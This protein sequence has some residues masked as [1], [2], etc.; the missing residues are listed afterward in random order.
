MK[1]PGSKF[2]FQG[3][4]GLYVL[5]GE[6]FAL[7]TYFCRYLINVT[8]GFLETKK[9]FLFFDLSRVATLL[10]GY[11]LNYRQPSESGF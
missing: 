4:W 6:K 9:L 8:R 1:S 11:P 2:D 5:W 7:Y 3:S 10:I